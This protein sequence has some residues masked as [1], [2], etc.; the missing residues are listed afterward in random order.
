M[1]AM[2]SC[3]NTLVMN[4]IN[5]VLYGDN[6]VHQMKNDPRTCEPNLCN[7]GKMLLPTEL[8]KSLMF[9]AGQLCV[10]VISIMCSNPVEVLN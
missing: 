10:H 3:E 2:T 8:L 4:S 7:C 1:A 5:R 6:I 9:G